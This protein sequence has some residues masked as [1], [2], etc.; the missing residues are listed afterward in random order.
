MPE[1]N[2]L[3]IH[4][5][6]QRY[7]SLGSSGNPYARTPNLDRLAAEGTCFTRHISS[8]TIC[9]PSRASLFTALYPPGHNVWANGVALNRREYVELN[10]RVVGAD[11]RPEPPTLADVFA[12]A[13]YDTAA[14]GKL[15]LTPN[16]APA[17]Y[18][19]PETWVNWDAGRFDDWHGPYYGFRHVETT[20]GHGEQPCHRGHYA[21]WLQHEHPGVYREVE[22]SDSISRPVPELRDLYPS[23]VPGELH[24]TRWLAD[25]FCAYL[26]DRAA[27]QP[28]FAFIGFPDPHH[29]FTPSH[30]VVRDFEGIAVPDPVDP[31]GESI[32]G[33]PLADAGTDVSGFILEDLRTIRRYTYAMIHQIDAAVGRIIEGLERAGIWDETIIVFTSDHGDFLGD[34]GRLRKGFTPAESL[35]HLPFILRAPDA[36]LPARVDIPMSNVDVLP[37]LTSLTGVTPPD[38]VHG[39]DMTEVI[40]REEDHVALA[41]CSNG[42]PDVTNYTLVDTHRRYTIY[43][44]RDYAELYDHRTDPGECENLIQVQPER[45]VAMR[46]HIEASLIRHRNPILGRVSAW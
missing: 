14:F 31:T 32:V 9:M 33:A 37:T 17:S 19:Y 20:Q 39:V 23:P 4:T 7:D 8:N 24:N 16:L 41:Y 43:P 28:F 45:M 42:D 15:H 18:G 3:V 27:G 13:G 1:P 35:L 2:V 11:V 34:H 40:R 25:R 10:T 30:D 12:E 44:Q 26:A 29:P 36:V 46:R 22:A 5:D 6:Q 21:A 38:R